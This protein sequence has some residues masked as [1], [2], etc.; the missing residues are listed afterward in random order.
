MLKSFKLSFWRMTYLWIEKLDLALWWKDG[1]KSWELRKIKGKMLSCLF[2]A[3]EHKILCSQ[4]SGFNNFLPL[5][6]LFSKT[7]AVSVHNAQSN[8]WYNA[9]YERN[10]DG[11]E[12]VSPVILCV[13]VGDGHA[14]VAPWVVT[15]DCGFI[16]PIF[17]YPACTL[18]CRRV[19]AAFYIHKQGS[20]Y[21]WRC[22]CILLLL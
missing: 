20:A 13:Q 16:H 15:G 11:E 12:Q 9:W 4:A 18:N 10:E 14:G 3:P 8:C 22:L 6:L 2:S 17:T 19:A 7:A 1:L 5:L 21:L